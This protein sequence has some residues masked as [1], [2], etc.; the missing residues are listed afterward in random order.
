MIALILIPPMSLPAAMQATAL[1][2]LLFAVALA[3]SAIGGRALGWLIDLLDTPKEFRD[4]NQATHCTRE[5][6]VRLGR[7]KAGKPVFRAPPLAEP[8]K[9]EEPKP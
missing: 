2:V 1:V 5:W 4:E 6:D 7:W 8:A 3:L 9:T